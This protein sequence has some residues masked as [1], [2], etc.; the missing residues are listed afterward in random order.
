M[1]YSNLVNKVFFYVKW[2]DRE[3]TWTLEAASHKL[4]HSGKMKMELLR[5]GSMTAIYKEGVWRGGISDGA[6]NS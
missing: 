5:I 2:F 6:V 1:G 4:P 3:D